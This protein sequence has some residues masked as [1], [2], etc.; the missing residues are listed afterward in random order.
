MRSRGLFLILIVA[1]VIIVGIF[2]YL[3][4][5][6]SPPSLLGPSRLSGKYVCTKGSESSFFK[7]DVVEFKPNGEVYLPP[8][9]GEPPMVAK[10][11][12]ERDMLTIRVDVLGSQYIL[13]GTIK[14]NTIV[15]DDG[16]ILE[17]R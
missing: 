10:Y 14:D 13:R 17:K 2:A 9:S 7:G 16:A 1:V 8:G 12:I 3:K 11:K 5:F 6:S 4:F 15:F